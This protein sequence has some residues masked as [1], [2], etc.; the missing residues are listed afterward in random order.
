MDIDKCLLTTIDD[1]VFADQ[2]FMINLNAP[3][4]TL[5]YK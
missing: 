2:T 3:P 1:Q 5:V 4:V